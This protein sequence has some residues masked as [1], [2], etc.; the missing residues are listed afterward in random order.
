MIVDDDRVK[1]TDFGIAR[2]LSVDTLMGTVATTGMRVGT[3]LYMSPEQVKGRKVDAR[4]DVY[5]FGAVLY[6]MVTGRSPF[7]G[8]DALAIAVQQM[9]EQAE[10]P[11]SVR[12]GVPA[13]WDALILKSLNK[14]PRRRFQSMTEMKREIDGL[15]T[16]LSDTSHSLVRN[17][18]FAMAG[19]GLLIFA[20]IGTML[21][22]SAAAGQARGATLA[23]YLAG[24]AAKD[25]LSGTVLVATQGKTILDRGYGYA[26]R[27][28]HVPNRAN[29]EYGLSDSTTNALLVADALQGTQAEWGIHPANASGLITRLSYSIC[30]RAYHRFYG[31]GCPRKWRGLTIANL[32]EGTSGLPDYHRGQNSGNMVA[33]QGHCYLLPMKRRNSHRVDYS[34][35]NDILLGF[36]APTIHNLGSTDEEWLP[37]GI[38]PGG[39]GTISFD[40]HHSRFLARQLFDG[41]GDPRLAIDYSA[42]GIHHV[43]SYNDYYAAYTSARDLYEYDR[44]PFSGNLMSPANTR[45]LVTA[46]DMAAPKDPGIDNVQWADGWK[47]GRLFGQ[48]ITYTAGR[49]ND[50]G[51]ANLWFPKFNSAVIVMANTASTD[52]L[53]VAEHVAAFMLPGRRARTTA[54]GA[55]TVADLPGTYVRT[56]RPADISVMNQQTSSPA[57]VLGFPPSIPNGTGTYGDSTLELRIN[58]QYVILGAKQPYTAADSGALTL[59]GPRPGGQD[60]HGCAPALTGLMSPGYYHWSLL[61]KHLFINKVTDWGPGFI[62]CYARA[63]LMPGSW[64]R[65]S[66]SG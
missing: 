44:L 33:A 56:E 15:R 28:G 22:Y 12:P 20:L 47:V 36:V 2:I 37:T 35:C 63:E 48:G 26:N 51:T 46:R 11:S 52:A 58:R 60:F 17:R 42:A 53:N 14:D 6:H 18:W 24:A 1:V 23:T 64:T 41:P 30:N 21:G 55:P 7:D 57:T 32:V 34:S 38:L 13:D 5:G 49:L 65:V 9:Q 27:A 8:D 29:T 50:Y 40:G 54:T 61:G 59:F 31:P 3:P 25:Q 19:V 39:R 16:Q 45:R 62:G 66:E 43:A 4:S 10:R